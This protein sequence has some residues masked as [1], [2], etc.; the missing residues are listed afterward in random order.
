M[1]DSDKWQEIFGTIRKNKLRTFLTL[2]GIA[3]GMFMLI[4]LL[5]GGNSFRTGVMG[6]FNFA[7]NS[8]FLWGRRTTISHNGFQPGKR[9]R[10][11]NSDT[12]MILSRV[13]EMKYL[14]PRNN[15][16][17][18][19]TVYKDKKGSFEVYGDY[20]DY[21]KIEIQEIPIGRFIN[22]KDIEDSRKVVVI[23][24]GVQKILFEEEEDPIGKFITIKKVNFRI[25]G[26]IKPS[27]GGG[28]RESAT[29]IHVPFTT[30]QKAFNYGDNVG[31]YG[32]SIVD[33]ADLSVIEPQ[34]IKLLKEKNNINPLDEDA[35]GHFNLQA[36]YE[37]MMGLFDGMKYFT[38][39][40]G[41]ST[42]FAGI[43]GISNIMLIIVKERTKEIGIRKS[44]GATPSS[45]VSLIIQESV[46]LTLVGGY[47][48][49]VGGLGLL[50]LIGMIMPADGDMPFAAPT[51]NA[52]V[53]VGALGILVVGGA[54]AG[55]LP[56]RKAAA[57]SP[58]E[59]IRVDG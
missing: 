56:A 57:V 9:V 3:C 8:G 4:I 39:F 55:I 48:A 47:I 26:I 22:T 28:D 23:G 53:P 34:L 25:V 35:V 5:G 49:L 37:E 13:K 6:D 54:L 30:F 32:Y 18:A 12:R 20:P 50:E 40:V 45:I 41:I 17:S 19:L 10:F 21:N 31:W 16:G 36:E 51:V 33:D 15:L 24:A 42:L 52:M 11:D 14:A 27:R 59:A 1:F 7:T 46:F 44:L 29:S 38:W 2:L 58:I 43:I